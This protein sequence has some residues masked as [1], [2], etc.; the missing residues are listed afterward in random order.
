MFER[1]HLSKLSRQLYRAAALIFFFLFFFL[2]AADIWAQ[3]DQLQV[4]EPPKSSPPAVESSGTSA[5]PP[6]GPSAAPASG[7]ILPSQLPNGRTPAPESDSTPAARI[8]IRPDEVTV[9]VN[10]SA[11]FELLY[12]FPDGFHQTKQEDFFGITAPEAS[13]FRVREVVYP[14]SGVMENGV[15][16]YYGSAVLRVEIALSSDVTPGEYRVPFTAGYQLCDD[17]GTCYFPS[18][19]IVEVT[20]WVPEG[21]A[22]ASGTGPGGGKAGDAAADGAVPVGE[23]VGAAGGG[24]GAAALLRFLLFAFIGGLLLNVMPCVLPVLSIR[25]LNLVNQSGNSRREIFTGSLLYTA[26]VLA[27][28]LVLA[29]AVIALKLSGELVGWG[30]QF[31]NPLF[32]VFLITVIFVF[33][34]SLF[35]VYVFQAP[36]MNGAVRRASQK[37]YIGSFFNGIIAV[38][39]A[40]PCTAPLLGTA[41]GFAF[42]QPPLMIVGIF[43]MV[44]TGFAL[45]FLL[46]GIWPAAI[47]RLPKPGEWMNTFKE[48]MGFVLL[49]TVIYLL[50]ILRFQIS[51]EEMIQVLIFLLVLG[52]LLWVYGKSAKPTAGRKKKW[53]ILA[54]FIILSVSAAGRLLQFEERGVTTKNESVREGWE[55]FSPEALAEYR[56][57]GKPVLVVFSA[58]WCT[59]CKLNEQTVLHT[60]SAEELFES[61]DLRVLYGD[62][63]NQ[64]KIIGEWIQAYGRAGVP[65]YAYYPPGSSSYRLLPEVLSMQILESSLLS[66][67][68]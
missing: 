11:S 28:L 10:E 41:L 29:G 55:S 25:A 61:L 31:Q 51:Q 54:L 12:E 5:V 33:A 30:F 2:T 40:T 44:G 4:L 49:G 14:E 45:P 21:T 67:S 43:T 3:L 24:A 58:K 65:V 57:A 37:G 38:L 52:F 23:N 32:V 35:D 47:Q 7:S 27:S 34:L 64:D 60:E 8:S 66:P 26:G 17:A 15:L 22:A 20:F 62:Y 56:Q 18:E 36:A 39:L 16:T 9:A 1:R 68:P 46:I 19:E 42:S 59:V 6:S 53:I 13:P 48:L 50:S 63:T